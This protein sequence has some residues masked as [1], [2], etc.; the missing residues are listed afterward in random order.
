VF[1]HHL[2]YGDAD[3]WP[4]WLPGRRQ[5]LP[6]PWP[7]TARRRR[8][9]NGDEYALRSRLADLDPLEQRATRQIRATL[10]RAGQ[11][12]ADEEHTMR[13][14]LYFRNEVLGLLAQAGFEDITVH[15]GYA[16]AEATAEQAMLVF[17]ARK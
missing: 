12:L 14:S 15:G 17:I 2:P 10:W 11:L 3:Q 4:Y 13:E 8:A 9:A 6:Q 1:N 16:A 7:T 5:R